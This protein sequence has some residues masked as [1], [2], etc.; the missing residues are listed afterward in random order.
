MAT[1]PEHYRAA[2]GCMDS[3]DRVVKSVEG[4]RMTEHESGMLR[5]DIAATLAAAQVHATLA[6]AAATAQ[7]IR[8]NGA[9]MARVDDWGEAIK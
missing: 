6:L 1:G 3:A 2:E 9:F 4:K 7:N 5:A 8:R